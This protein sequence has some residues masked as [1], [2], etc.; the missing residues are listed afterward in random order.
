MVLY[1]K[2]YAFII[3]GKKKEEKTDQVIVISRFNGNATGQLY[4]E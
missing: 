1:Q 2:F 4:L 3:G